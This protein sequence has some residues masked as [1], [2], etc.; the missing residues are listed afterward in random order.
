VLRQGERTHRLVEHG[1]RGHQLDPGKLRAGDASLLAVV[2]H[3]RQ[4]EDPGE[5]HARRIL[6]PQLRGTRDERGDQR[7]GV[8]RSNLQPSGG[9]QWLR[10]RW[11]PRTRAV[12]VRRGVEEQ[13]LA[14][15]LRAD[16]QRDIAGAHEL[17]LAAGCQQV[18]HAAR[19]ERDGPRH[20]GQA[21]RRSFTARSTGSCAPSS[22][23]IR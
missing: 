23:S 12:G 5:R 2:G 6:V 7:L 13:R 18:E 16:D 14:V 1:Q 10:R 11:L 22:R 3:E 21:V 8:E 17:Q 20:R 4:P 15:G 9:A 19:I